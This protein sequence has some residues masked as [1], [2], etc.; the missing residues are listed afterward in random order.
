MENGKK[1]IFTENKIEGRNAVLEA[2]RSGRS[3]DKI[4]VLMGA[5]D[6]PISRFSGKLRSMIQS[7]VMYRKNG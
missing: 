1:E 3:V 7:S 5:H 6:G 2:L 4:Y